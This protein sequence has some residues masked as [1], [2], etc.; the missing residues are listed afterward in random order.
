MHY[1]KSS[2]HSG[3]W[4]EFSSD[5]AI[6]ITKGE[7]STK[8]LCLY[9]KDLS[10]A[11]ALASHYPDVII[12]KLDGS[13]ETVEFKDGSGVVR[14]FVKDGNEIPDILSNLGTGDYGGVPLTIRGG[15]CPGLPA[16][17]GET[18]RQMIGAKQVILLGDTI[19][20]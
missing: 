14:F 17:Y 12:D 15:I 4:S 7:I 20:W 5:L 1:F 8:E 19:S 10:A 18:V 9:C 2:K 13:P 3:D 11:T 16:S 6:K